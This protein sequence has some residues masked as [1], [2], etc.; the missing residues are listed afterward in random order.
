MKWKNGAE[1]LKK[2]LHKITG[3]D[4]G[5]MFYIK[6]KFYL[7]GKPFRI[8]SGAVHYFRTVPGYWHDRLEKLINMGCNTV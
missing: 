7:N 3:D 4:L 8:I 2:T 6:D 5:K 1:N